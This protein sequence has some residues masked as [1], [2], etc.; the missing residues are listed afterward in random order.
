MSLIE[1]GNFTLHSGETSTWRI[2]A[3]ALGDDDLAA[4]A[5]IMAARLPG[6]PVAVHGIPRGGLRMATAMEP[7]CDPSGTYELVVDDVVTTGRS[8]VRTAFEL[9][10]R[11][12]PPKMVRLMAIFDR[13]PP[14]RGGIAPVV[15]TFLQVAPGDNRAGMV[16]R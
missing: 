8:L 6:P 15:H 5:A 9:L 10:Q 11:P 2:N 7:Y 13:R 3:D 1:H 12:D 4:I 16:S 14:M